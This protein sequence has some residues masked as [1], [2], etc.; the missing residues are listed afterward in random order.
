MMNKDIVSAILSK[1]SGRVAEAKV[2]IKA[3][4]DARATQFRS[5]SSKFIAKSLFEAVDEESKS[6]IKYHK[7]QADT[8]TR[9]AH[10]HSLKQMTN[11]HAAN[12]RHR[13]ATIAH[14]DASDAHVSAANR[15]RAAGASEE[16]KKLAREADS[17]SDY[18]H[19]KSLDTSVYKAD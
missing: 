13:A 16:T 2:A 12:T 19:Q 3:L 8:H 18:A 1:D 9:L 14:A 17:K 10:G 5:D 7:A 6:R 4:L 15:F 11:D